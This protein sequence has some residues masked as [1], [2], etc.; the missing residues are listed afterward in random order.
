M[1]KV[2]NLREILYL[3]RKI[4][5]FSLILIMTVMTSGIVLAEVS[6]PQ[7]DQT[8]F[9]PLSIPASPAEPRYISGIGSDN[10]YTIFYED[11][12][13]GLGCSYGNRIYFIQTSN[14]PANFSSPAATN[15][16]DTHFVVKDWPI[17]I[18]ATTYPYRAWGSRTNN[19]QH[20]YYVAD[21]LGNW[22]L[23]STFT[24]SGTP[25]VYYGFHDIIQVNG[26]YMGFAETNTSETVLVWSDEGTDTWTVID[27]VGGAGD[28]PL[29]LDV[30]GSG[31]GPTP[32]GSFIRM[33]VNGQQVLGKLGVPGDNSGAYLAINQAFVEAGS[34]AAAEAAF[35]DPLNWSWHDG[36]TGLPGAGMRVLAE[37]SHDIREVWTVPLSNYRSDH[38]I[39]YT[40]RYGSGSNLGCAASNPECLV[41]DPPAE[42]LPATG[43]S[44]GKKTRTNEQPALN[45]ISSEMMLNIPV[46]DLQLPIIGV[47]ITDNGWDVNWLGEQAGYL[48][49]TAFPTWNGNTVIT[50]HV[51]DRFNQP[52]AFAD[53]KTLSYGDLVEIHAWDRV[54]TYEVREKNLVFPGMVENVL[55]H[56][57]YDWITLL[58][59]EF[60]NPLTDDYLFRRSVKAVLIEVK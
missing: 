52:G 28:D 58:T 24:V 10:A 40:G 41:I 18:G 3:H 46:L 43:F 13:D 39:F 36:S 49:G 15:I 34:P 59:C 6:V 12:N 14:G 23:I 21:S 19:N 4:L 45:P 22:T 29:D 51:W 25:I 47:P 8:E 27:I 33:E 7:I 17:S 9:T 57:E 37:N 54:Y 20:N 50:G 32:T 55:R 53:L 5:A 48:S 38:V 42:A 35:L 60:Y 2:S 30:D 1:I 56:E 44:K 31:G 26:N 16:C 11:R